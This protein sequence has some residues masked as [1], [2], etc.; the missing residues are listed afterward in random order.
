LS[1]VVDILQA[2]I[3]RKSKPIRD[4]LPFK[5]QLFFQ[6]K[7]KEFAIRVRQ[8]TYHMYYSVNNGCLHN[9]NLIMTVLRI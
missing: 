5:S 2:V 4:E 3:E 7:V 1:K 9:K 6:A 8:Q